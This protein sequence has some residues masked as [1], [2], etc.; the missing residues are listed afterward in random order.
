VTTI[1]HFTALQHINQRLV[2]S[3][4]YHFRLFTSSVLCH[5]VCICVS[6]LLSMCKLS[7]NLSLMLRPT[8]SRPDCLGIKHPSGAQDQILLL[9][10]SCGFVDVGRFLWREDGSIVHNYCWP[11]PAQSFSGPSTVELL[12]IFYCLRFETSLFVASYDSQGYGGDIRPRLHTG[13]LNNSK[14]KFQ[15]AIPLRRSFA[16]WIGDTLSKG[17]VVVQTI[18]WYS[19][20]SS[21]SRWLATTVSLFIS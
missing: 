10:D 20:R 4:R 14:S 15:S 6:F 3:V 11:L 7:L 2:L 12:T 13:C 1:I 21:P 5:S 18:S 16:N 9:S 19:N 17:W 8:V